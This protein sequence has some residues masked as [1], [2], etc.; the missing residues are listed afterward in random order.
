MN[1]TEPQ[2]GSDLS[3]V[4]CRAER[5][6]DQFRIRGAKTFI[7]W[8][9]HELSANVIHTVLARIDG[10]PEGVRGISMFL[11]LDVPGAEVPARRER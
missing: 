10:A 11:V 3:A 7:T 2:A 9:D 1:L 4:A 5:D 8:G 6:G